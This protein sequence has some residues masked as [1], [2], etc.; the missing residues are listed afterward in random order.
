MILVRGLY[1]KFGD[2]DIALPKHVNTYKSSSM[3]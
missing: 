2:L 1:L 3:L